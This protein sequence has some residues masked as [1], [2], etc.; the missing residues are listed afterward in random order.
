MAVLKK[1][2]AS[3]TH[4]SYTLP[5]LGAASHCTAFSSPLMNPVPALEFASPVRC[6]ILKNLFEIG[7][8]S[9]NGLKV[10]VYID[11]EALPEMV[12][13]ISVHLLEFGIESL[14]DHLIKID[15]LAD[16]VVFCFIVTDSRLFEFI[17]QEQK[18]LMSL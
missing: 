14:F 6:I 4:A 16:E 2:T 11:R 18:L 17:V 8:M 7:N 9:I 3:A 1:K 13:G 15:I 10:E 5:L 12:P